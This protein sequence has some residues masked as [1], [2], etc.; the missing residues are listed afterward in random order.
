MYVYK[1]ISLGQ[2][3]Q[4]ITEGVE[5]CTR[6]VCTYITTVFCLNYKD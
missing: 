6:E 5:N 3:F 2:S 1:Q 4:N